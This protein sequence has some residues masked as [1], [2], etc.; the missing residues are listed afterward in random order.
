MTVL[1]TGG[2]GYIG[3]HMVLA[4]LDAGERVI[5]LDD[6]STGFRW[7][8]P[9][10]AKL[11]V[12]D[13]GD[14]SLV[15]KLCAAYEIDTIAHFAAKII[16]PESTAAPLPY[17][18]TNTAKARNLL[19][20]AVRNSVR[21]FIFSSTAAVYGEPAVVPIPETAALAPI[22]PYG[23]SKL[24]AEWMLRDTAA[25]HGLKFAILRYFNVA[26]ADPKGRL[27]QSTAKATHL[28]KIAAQAA[29]GIRHYVEVYGSDYP[30]PDGTCIRD[31]VQVTDLVDAHLL[32]LSHLRAGGENLI[33]NCGYGYGFSVLEVIGAMK[34]ASGVDFEVRMAARRPGDPAS[35][36]AATDRIS[37]V[38]G[39]KPK[40]ASLEGIA[41]QALA[42]EHKL[43]EGSGLGQRVPAAPAF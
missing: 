37:S 1:V 41:S 8:V 16:V 12:G 21:H 26:G 2:A 3:G 42:W 35:L 43:K 39:W 36:V 25:A 32:A 6:L 38:L 29:V 30:T 15:D 34:R 11:I 14:A 13:A 24:A 40:Y 28:F 18:L 27:G 19:D 31:Y 33:C 23:R 20:C 5:V 7:A 17:Y 10:A 9:A 22:N 4:L